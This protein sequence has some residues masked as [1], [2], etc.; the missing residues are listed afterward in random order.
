MNPL[1]CFH[2]I[3]AKLVQ[4][5]CKKD[6]FLG[7]G[8]YENRSSPS[9]PMLDPAGAYMENDYE[10]GVGKSGGDLDAKLGKPTVRPICKKTPKTP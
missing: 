3:R 8:F 6:L 9:Q 10:L 2:V 7:C 5:S 4:D 1:R